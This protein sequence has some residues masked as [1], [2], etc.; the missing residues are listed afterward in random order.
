MERRQHPRRLAD[1][2]IRVTD[3]HAGLTYAGHVAD[4]SRTGL[5]VFLASQLP[6]GTPLRLEAADSVLYGFVV[7]SVT[8]EDARVRTGIEL[9]QVLI[10]ATDLSRVLEHNLRAFLPE[11][12]GLPAPE[13]YLG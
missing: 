10:G 8:Q 2:D 4:L 7:S 5:G 13:A 3:L 12:T 9:Q 1:L 11:V 6:D